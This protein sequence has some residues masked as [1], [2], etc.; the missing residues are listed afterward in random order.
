MEIGASSGKILRYALDDKMGMTLWIVGIR[1]MDK[2]S[3][4]WPNQHC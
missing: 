1:P 2:G 4:S 3:D